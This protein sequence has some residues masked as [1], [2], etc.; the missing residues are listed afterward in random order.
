MTLSLCLEEYKEVLQGRSLSRQ[1]ISNWSRAIVLFDQLLQQKGK[2]DVRETLPEDF[3]DYAEF[4]EDSELASETRRQY[5]YALRRFF[6]WLYRNEVI[7]TPLEGFVPVVKKIQKEKVLFTQEEIGCFLDAIEDNYHDRALFELLYSSG[8]R[9]SEALNLKWKDVF[10]RNRKLW[11]K[12]GKGHR[13]RCVPFSRTASLFLKRW[14]KESRLRD[15]DYLF[16]GRY[17]QKKPISPFSIRQRFLK[18]LDKAEITREGLTIHSIRHSTATHLLEAGVDI[19]YVS[20]L[21]GHENMETTAVYTHPTEDSQKKAF[22]MYHPRENG[23]YREIDQA[24]LKELQ[25]LRKKLNART[26]KNNDC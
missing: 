2:E 7:L 8:L 4:L 9:I 16:P 22:R 6:S 23:C 19:R 24:Y 18:Y 10:M 13:D 21:L 12:Q 20:E 15:D 26:Q 11:I 5:L 1:T 17:S 3:T 25:V 14:K